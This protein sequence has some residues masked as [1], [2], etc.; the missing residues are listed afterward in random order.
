MKL[1][2][3]PGV[4]SADRELWRAALQ[5]HCEGNYGVGAAELLQRRGL[6]LS[7]LANEELVM[8]RRRSC[9]TIEARAALKPG[10]PPGGMSPLTRDARVGLRVS[11]GVRGQGGLLAGPV[12][13]LADD[14]FAEVCAGVGLGALQRHQLD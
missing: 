11:Q 1:S 2:V 8:H 14:A 4:V 9:Y 12:K 3:S 7:S 13:V 10:K 6:L 5:K